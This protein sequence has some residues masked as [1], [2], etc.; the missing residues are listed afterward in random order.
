MFGPGLGLVQQDGD[1]GACGVKAEAKDGKGDVYDDGDY[2]DEGKGDVMGSGDTLKPWGWRPMGRLEHHFCPE[3]APKPTGMPD[4][5]SFYP[6]LVE[7]LH[8]RFCR[9]ERLCQHAAI[10]TRM[11]GWGGGDAQVNQSE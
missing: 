3:I 9:A 8:S 11:V 6:F 5:L 7:F 4:I 1:D 10:R 2:D